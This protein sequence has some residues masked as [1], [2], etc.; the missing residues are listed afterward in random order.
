MKIIYNSTKVLYNSTINTKVKTHFGWG[1]KIRLRIVISKEQSDWD[2]FPISF[3][4]KISPYGRNDKEL[5]YRRNKV[6]EISFLFHFQKKISRLHSNWQSNVISK[7]QSDWDIFPISFPEK[8]SR[9]HSNWQSNV[10]SKEQSDWDIFPISISEMISL[11][12]NRDRNDS[13]KKK[14]AYKLIY[15]A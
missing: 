8:I 14:A 12:I 11:P 15:T 10:I 3:S 4:E 13:N 7:E 5:S 9:L 6:T 2:I 1:F